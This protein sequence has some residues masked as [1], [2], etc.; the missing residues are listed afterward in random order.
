MNLWML[1]SFAA[2]SGVTAIYLLYDSDCVSDVCACQALQWAWSV[3]T[4][5]PTPG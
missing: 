1:T 4:A 3:L 5:G 2:C